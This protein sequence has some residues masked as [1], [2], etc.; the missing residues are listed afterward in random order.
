MDTGRKAAAFQPKSLYIS[1]AG[2][3]EP[4]RETPKPTGTID[5]SEWI[6]TIETESEDEFQST[7]DLHHIRVDQKGG[8]I[9]QQVK[10]SVAPDNMGKTPKI[11]ETSGT[12]PYTLR[13]SQEQMAADKAKAQ[14]RM[15]QEAA[16]RAA[17][18]LTRTVAEAAEEKQK[19]SKIRKDI[20]K[21]ESKIDAQTKAAR[22]AVEQQNKL[23]QERAQ[24]KAKADREQ[25]EQFEKEKSR[26]EQEEK[27]K[28]A[29]SKR[30]QKTTPAPGKGENKS[31]EDSSLRE[32]IA[33]IVRR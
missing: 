5:Q 16:D 29:K 15:A 21:I 33:I 17:K 22:E 1:P 10:G 31:P 9:P 14:Q 3:Q 30:S 32:R 7:E 24:Q 26:L 13:E 11:T 6:D 12:A 23:A 19:E 28:T 25:Q 2:E 4:S 27:W 8:S 18:T 20:Q